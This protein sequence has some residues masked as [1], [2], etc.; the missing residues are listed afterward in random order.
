MSIPLAEVVCPELLVR[1]IMSQAFVFKH[2]RC[3]LLRYNGPCIRMGIRA[4][5]PHGQLVYLHIVHI[6]LCMCLYVR[7]RMLARMLVCYCLQAEACAITP[8]E[9]ASASHRGARTSDPSC[10]SWLGLLALA[11]TPRSNMYT[12]IVILCSCT[13]ICIFACMSVCMFCCC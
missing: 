4:L 13:L 3:P 5:N 7:A 6:H 10:P 11:R 9:Q 8:H 1:T 2:C 12:G